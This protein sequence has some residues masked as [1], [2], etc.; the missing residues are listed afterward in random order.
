MYVDAI[1]LFGLASG[2]TEGCGVKDHEHPLRL[3]D[4]TSG[5]NVF[6][7]LDAERTLHLRFLLDLL[8][9]CCLDADR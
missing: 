6:A 2:P 3:E 7:G 9:R 5:H 4:P 8:T 1:L